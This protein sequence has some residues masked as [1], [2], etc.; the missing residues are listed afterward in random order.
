ME[1]LLGDRVTGTFDMRLQTSYS[2]HLYEIS[3]IISYAIMM[4]IGIL[5]ATFEVLRR[6]L[7]IRIVLL[8]HTMQILKH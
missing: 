1:K 8:V 3:P 6:A 7:T 4:N 2:V 5:P